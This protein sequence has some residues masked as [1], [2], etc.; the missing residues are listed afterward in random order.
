[1][2]IV[3]IMPLRA[4]W[5]KIETCTSLV[6]CQNCST[7]PSVYAHAHVNFIFRLSYEDA[8]IWLTDAVYR[9]NQLSPPSR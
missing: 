8:S 7:I 1:M 2:L 3:V 9:R 5:V 6:S 4:T